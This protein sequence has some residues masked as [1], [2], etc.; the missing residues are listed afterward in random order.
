MARVLGGIQH[1][2]EQRLAPKHA[3]ELQRVG[4]ILPSLH[5]QSQRLRTHVGRLSTRETLRVGR[6]AAKKEQRT[7]SVF[8]SC[9]WNSALQNSG[10]REIASL[11]GPDTIS[12]GS[13]AW[14]IKKRSLRAAHRPL[15]THGPSSYPMP[16]PTCRRFGRR[17]LQRAVLVG[18]KSQFTHRLC[19]GSSRDKIQDGHHGG[20]HDGDDCA[21]EMRPSARAGSHIVSTLPCDP[22]HDDL[23]RWNVPR[24]SPAAHLGPVHHARCAMAAPEYAL[25]LPSLQMMRRDSGLRRRRRWFCSS[26]APQHR[27][28]PYPARGP[29][30]S[31]ALGRARH[32]CARRALTVTF[33]M[34]CL[35]RSIGPLVTL[36]SSG[37]C[38]AQALAQVK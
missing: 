34:L 7:C 20:P 13:H 18:V 23:T 31:Q 21:G 16:R 29:P 24:R 36:Y 6:N 3:D 15:K 25:V 30:P 10:T 27:S 35:T 2:A 4:N 28:R 12:G 38:P 22:L 17:T 5:T 1:H 9:S 11:V 33:A 19:I 37:V 14:H 8:T 32:C 26:P